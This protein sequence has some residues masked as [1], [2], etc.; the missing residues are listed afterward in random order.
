MG[1]YVRLARI[2]PAVSVQMQSFSH[3]KFNECEYIEQCM[4]QSRNSPT[5]YQASVPDSDSFTV[6]DAFLQSL[7][8]QACSANR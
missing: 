2:Q 1:L 3:S 7:D 5:V 6:I 4:Y 8:Q